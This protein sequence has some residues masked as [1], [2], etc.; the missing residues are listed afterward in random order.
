MAGERRG[1]KVGWR[2]RLRSFWRKGLRPIWHDIEWPLVGGVWALA[3]ILG[4]IGFSR[5]SLAVGEASTGWNAF[6]RALQLI[7]LQSGDIAGPLPWQLQVSR[8]LMPAVAGYAAIQAL[9][10]VFREQWHIFGLRFAKG[11]AMV[12]AG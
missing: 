12:W 8:F 10:A 6:Y 3:L 2:N 9:L 5:H 11:H 4:Y 7:V 1:T